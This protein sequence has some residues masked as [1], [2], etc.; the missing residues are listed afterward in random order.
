[1]ADCVV[2][3]E[4]GST[5][6][7]KRSVAV[8]MCGALLEKIKDDL[9]IARTDNEVDMRYMINMDYA[10]DLNINTM[11]RR[12]RTRL[13]FTSESHLHT[14]LNVLRFFSNE[15]G[16]R[17][18]LLS[19][20]GN[21]LV[22]ETPELCYLTQIVMRLFEDTQKDINDPRRFR[23]EILFSPG[24]TAT[25]LHMAE[26]NRDR[27]SSRFETTKLV[28]I[29]EPGLTCQM[30]EDYFTDSITEGKIEEEEE[31]IVSAASKEMKKKEKEKKKKKNKEIKIESV[32]SAVNAKVVDQLSVTCP[33]E[34]NDVGRSIGPLG[35][36]V[37]NV[38]THKPNSPDVAPV[39]NS[40]VPTAFAKESKKCSTEEPLD[41]SANGDAGAPAMDSVERSIG[42][43]ED[44][45]EEEEEEDKMRH[46]SRVL[47]RQY[48]W[49]SVA[50]VSFVL[51]MGCLT[52]AL[53]PW[54]R[55]R[56]LPRRFNT[57]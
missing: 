2:P 52:L 4:Y 29:S 37:P 5:I 57:R 17:H 11:G 33:A 48:F 14:L 18:S 21:A 31:D 53:G 55:N 34:N 28:S 49:T 50:A 47:A 23:V 12:I 54:G 32:E 38:S 15:K 43:D 51:G 45:E 35:K 46:L 6:K 10:A 36:E 41:A 16:S 13:Y 8:K 19:Q 40:L 24:A 25:P 9:I 1:M 20:K 27:D 26:M 3:Q 42:T 39:K 7:E 44:I 56:S 30:T 22:N